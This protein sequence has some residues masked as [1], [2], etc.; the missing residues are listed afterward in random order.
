MKNF[1]LSRFA[2][3]VLIGWLCF[4]GSACV[5]GGDGVVG[6]TPT[7]SLNGS[8]WA[9]YQ[10]GNVSSSAY[11]GYLDS[12][13]MKLTLHYGPG[14]SSDSDIYLNYSCREDFGDVRFTEGDG[15]TPL[16]YWI[17]KYSPGV[18]ATVWVEFRGIQDLGAG[19]YVFHG[20][21]DA[22]SE[23][24]GKNTF[25]IFNDGSS[26]DGWLEFEVPPYYFNW[27][28][29][30][31]DFG[32]AIRCTS[33]D[34][35]GWSNLYWNASIGTD[36]Y[37]A[38]CKIR[39]EKGLTNDN[40]Q[41]GFSY[42]TNYPC[43]KWI[44]YRGFDCWQLRDRNGSTLSE[45]DINFNAAQWHDYSFVKNNNAWKLYV[46]DELKVTRNAEPVGQ[47]IGMYANFGAA[48]RWAEFDDFRVR[49]YCSP[50]PDFGDW[51]EP[52][53]LG[54]LVVWPTPISTGTSQ[55]TAEP[56]G[57]ATLKTVPGAT[58]TTEATEVMGVE[59]PAPMIP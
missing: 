19:F 41:Q 50:E 55:W 23:S 12:Y 51:G 22:E 37:A 14:N 40:Y 11:C 45:P 34:V 10:Q 29:V 31:S 38:E 6:P 43:V 47:L 16:D 3:V 20:N 33:V 44:D 58:S 21:L 56:T 5:G 25:M 32:K 13:T 57:T 36:S 39:A 15:E 2:V 53:L 30:S 52:V 17:Q 35:G 8:D 54:E 1:S 46:D 24:N 42:Y 59:T 27:Q 28:I 26:M 18:N 7:P 48:N 4:C 9:Y 49:E